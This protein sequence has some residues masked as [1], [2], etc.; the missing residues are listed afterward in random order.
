MEFASR[1][2]VVAEFCACV[3]RSVDWRRAVKDSQEQWYAVGGIMPSSED[4]ASRSGVRMSKIVEERQVEYVPVNFTSISTPGP[5]NL[6]VSSGKS[7]KRKPSRSP[8]KI[9]RL[10][11]TASPPP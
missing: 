2:Q 6:R 8:V 7:K 4:S 5:S 3:D 1:S 9:P 10:F 11:E